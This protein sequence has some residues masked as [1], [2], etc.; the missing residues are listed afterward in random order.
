MGNLDAIT[1]LVQLLF[2]WDWDDRVLVT[3]QRKGTVIQFRPDHNAEH[4]LMV[5][6]EMVARGFT[7]FHYER[8]GSGVWIAYFSSPDK[9]GEHPDSWKH[10]MV[11]AVIRELASA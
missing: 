9:C 5:L 7:T 4:V 6:D 10:A 3:W 2:G 11:R 8:S 1:K